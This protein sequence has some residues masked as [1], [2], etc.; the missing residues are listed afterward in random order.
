MTPARHGDAHLHLVH[1]PPPRQ[2]VCLRDGKGSP[3]SNFV[4]VPNRVGVPNLFPPVQGQ[5]NSKHGAQQSAGSCPDVPS[6]LRALDTL[7]QLFAS[8]LSPN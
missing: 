3:A 5:S 4:G 2:Q 7:E 1:G 8:N 6:T